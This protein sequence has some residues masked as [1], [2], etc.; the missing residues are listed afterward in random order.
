[1]LTYA[2]DICSPGHVE[3]AIAGVDGPM[4]TVF[5]LYVTRR[6]HAKRAARSGIVVLN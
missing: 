5:H 4:H 1:M 2:G 6:L 3:R